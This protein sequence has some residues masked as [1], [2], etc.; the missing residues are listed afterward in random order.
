MARAE[1]WFSE[2]EEVVAV[3]LSDPETGETLTFRF[4]PRDFPYV[5]LWLNF[6]GWNGAGETPYFNVAIEPTTAPSD[7]LSDA[8]RAGKARFLEPGASAFWSL[9]LSSSQ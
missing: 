2:K 4:E 7:N 6:H 5:G 3:E 8:V 9:Q 1:K